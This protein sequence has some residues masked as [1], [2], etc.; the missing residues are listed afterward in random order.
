MVSSNALATIRETKH[1]Q[2]KGA[3]LSHGPLQ[4]LSI[5]QFMISLLWSIQLTVNKVS[6]MLKNCS[7]PQEMMARN[8]LLITIIT[9]FY[10]LVQKAWPWLKGLIFMFQWSQS[11]KHGFIYNGKDIYKFYYWWQQFS[12]NYLRRNVTL[13]LL[14]GRTCRQFPFYSPRELN[15][16]S[17]AAVISDWCII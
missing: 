4:A 8:S 2:A 11:Q 15:S 1:T 12:F 7:F 9:G 5:N 3:E 6:N 16:Q 17:Q 14:L 13:L 10:H